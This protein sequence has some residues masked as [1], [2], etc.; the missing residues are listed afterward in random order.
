M[1]TTPDGVRLDATTVVYRNVIF[2]KP[3]HDTRQIAGSWLLDQNSLRERKQESF[4]VWACLWRLQAR[5]GRHGYANA[6]KDLLLATTTIIFWGLSSKIKIEK[7]PRIAFDLDYQCDHSLRRWKTSWQILRWRF[8]VSVRRSVEYRRHRN[9]IV[10]SKLGHNIMRSTSTYESPDFNK[11]MSFRHG[12]HVL[13][14]PSSC[15]IRRCQPP[16]SDA[17][18]SQLCDPKI[19][20]VRE[21]KLRVRIYVFCRELSEQEKWVFAFLFLWLLV[22]CWKYN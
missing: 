4:K 2:G 10:R 5:M 20:I 3:R 7:A 11:S 21:R 9:S 18:S 13:W 17:N 16:T 22:G 19:E 8:N 12:E 15:I 14:S 1:T 6:T